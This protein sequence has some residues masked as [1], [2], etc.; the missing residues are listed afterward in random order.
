[1]QFNEYLKLCRENYS[2]TQG[3]LVS[4][5]Y[6]HDIDN[7]AS[8]DNTTLSKWERNIIQPRVSKQV[9]LIKYFQKHADIPL[10]CWDNYSIEEAEELI[11]RVGMKN[12]L[13]ENKQYVCNFPS[14]FIKM[15]ELII[16]P[17]RNCDDMNT[18]LEMNIELHKNMNH[19]STQISIEQFKA[20]ALHPSSS[21]YVCK[22]KGMY[23]GHI[24]SIRINPEILTKVLDFEMQKS[25]IELDDLTTFDE[26]GSEMLLSF[27][28]A[29][30]KSA[31]TLFIR[32]YAHL[33][34]NQRSIKEIGGL[35]KIN[36]AKKIVASM[37]LN[38]Y[39]RKSTDDGVVIEADRQTLNNAL[40]SENVVKMILTKQNC[41]E[42]I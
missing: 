12:L 21:F 20:W 27:F 24:F 1:M 39:K 37:N 25:D 31:T 4:D 15:D 29:N 36:E 32:Y 40:A 19:P 11:C 8:L 42:E 5:L 26:M 17:L 22:Y 33:I 18:I 16:Q 3:E 6:T 23:M 2:L 9:S 13:G 35:T 14:N 10:P 34:A 30:T 41:P 28:A 38:L 7:F